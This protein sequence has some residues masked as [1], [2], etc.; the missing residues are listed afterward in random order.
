MKMISKYCPESKD[1]ACR[2]GILS[3]EDRITTSMDKHKWNSHVQLPVFFPH[4]LFQEYMAGVH[5]AS[6]YESNRNEFKRLIE[7]VVL[8]RK[9]EFRYLL[10][11][12]VSQNKII[13]THVM[14]SMLQKILRG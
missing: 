4:K 12:T 10:Y 8:P 3:Q 1:T 2:V 9:E 14:K 7:K 5:L 11:F 6:L 13:A